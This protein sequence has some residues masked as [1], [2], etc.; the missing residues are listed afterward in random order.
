M[1]RI[2]AIV[3]FA[4][5]SF[6]AIDNANAQD[7]RM[8]VTIPFNFIAGRAHFSAGTYTI[9]SSDLIAVAIQNDKQHAFILKSAEAEEHPESGKLVF[10]RYGDQYV[11][12]KILSP[13]AHLYL[14]LPISKPVKS[15]R[16]QDAKVQSY[17]V[18]QIDLNQ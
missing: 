7:H 3:L 15:V 2:I 11:L 6:V 14:E 4:L 9:S 12:R 18:A 13:G 1:K 8:R 10:Y 5:A 17:E 16:A